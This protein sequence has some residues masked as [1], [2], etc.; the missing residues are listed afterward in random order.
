MTFSQVIKEGPLAGVDVT[1]I[2]EKA[3]AMLVAANEDCIDVTSFKLPHH[4]QPT[5]EYYQDGG[6]CVFASDG[7]T[8]FVRMSLFPPTHGTGYY[9]YGYQLYFRDSYRTTPAFPAIS[10]V[11][12]VPDAKID[13]M[14]K[15]INEEL[16]R[17][18]PAFDSQIEKPE[19]EPNKAPVPTATSVTPAADAPAAPAAAAAHLSVRQS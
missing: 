15:S 6:S 7:Y 2:P 18:T 4:A 17:R 19:T 10:K 5:H 3:R 12:L 1:G 11:W 9:S 14:R 8:I 13:A 16:K